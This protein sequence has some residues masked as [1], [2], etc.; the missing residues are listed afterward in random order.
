[1]Y[2]KKK[3]L[4][5]DHKK[6]VITLKEIFYI[7]AKNKIWFA[8]TFLV[9]SIC[10]LIFTFIRPTIYSMEASIILSDNYEYY[11]DFLLENFPGESKNLWL[12]EESKNKENENKIL[13]TID[14]EINSSEFIRELKNLISF[15]ID[16]DELAKSIYSYRKT[17]KILTIKTVHIDGGKAY[18]ILEKSVYLLKNSKR[19]EF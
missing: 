4:D 19:A 2:R 7:L 13:N 1:M 16:F 12:Y 3:I 6:K 8:V 18:E 10:G 11:D 9:V 15:D 14:S 5:I 17:G